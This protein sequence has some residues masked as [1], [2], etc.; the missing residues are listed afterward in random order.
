MDSYDVIVIGA[1]PGG[2][3]AAIRAAHRGAKVALIERECLGGTCLNWGCIPTKTL[4]HS[5]ELF[6]Q[7]TQ[8][9]ACGV[10]AQGVSFEWDKML[11]R[12]NEVVAKLRQGIGM[13]MKANGVTVIEGTGALVSRRQVRIA[14]KDC[15]TTVEGRKII[16]ATG[17]ESARPSAFPFNQTN[18][19]ESRALLD[20]P[21]L[22]QSMIIIGGGVIGCEFAS[23]LNGLGVQ[24]TIV[25]MLER[26]LPIEDKEISNAITRAFQKAG[27][28]VKTGVQAGNIQ[29]GPQ[30]V[31][32]DVA[33]V[34]LSAEMMLVAVGRALNTKGIGLE[35]AGVKTERGVIV[36]DD[37]MQT[38]IAGIYAIGDITGKAQLAHVASA[39]ALVAADNASGHA[40]RM[41]YTVV[42]NCIFT[43]PE[44][45][46]VG[47]SE[48]QA[49]T[50]A[51]EIRIGKF[52][53][54]A[55]G[56]ALAIGEP[57]GFYR[58]I[59]SATTDEILGVQIVGAHATD[60]IAEAALAIRLQCTAREFAQTIH[61][62]PTLA[63]GLMEAAHD[64]HGACIHAAPRK[65]G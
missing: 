46:T 7:M 53:Y 34:A 41:D 40:A 47:L 23:M 44:I 11:A 17:S 49:R 45:A 35:A 21:A 26:L 6:H 20:L 58:M 10:T 15:E 43:R 42:P 50:K 28:T 12:K 62:H 31:T 19:L 1:G 61:A 37:E 56:K 51:G 38:N 5:A 22:P 54:A 29:A 24:I 18:V 4:I 55:L 25:E 39:Q 13:L 36:V 9:G 65:R 57:D 16:I 33:G 52:P 63:E 2:Y 64:A 30:G 14:G 8:A 3:V 60:L 32:C 59:T 48:E 27:I